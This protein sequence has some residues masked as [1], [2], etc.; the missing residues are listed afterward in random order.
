MSNIVLSQPGGV[1]TLTADGNIQVGTRCYLSGTGVVAVSWTLSSVPAGSTATAKLHQTLGW[2]FDPDVRSETAYVARMVDS[3]AGVHTNS[4]YASSAPTAP[5]V[6]Q[7]KATLYAEWFGVKADGRRITDGIVTAGSKILQSS[8]A[9]FTPFDV[10]RSALLRTAS[11]RAQ[12]TLTVV[13][14]NA[15]ATVNGA[16]QVADMP[17]IGGGGATGQPASGGAICVGGN[18]VVVTFSVP[19]TN[20]FVLATTPT[21]N[22]TGMPYY[23]ETQLATTIVRY[24]DATHVELAHA[25]TITE[26]SVLG[27]IATDDTTALDDC[28]RF[29]FSSGAVRVRLP[30]GLLGISTNLLYRGKSALTIAGPC[31][32]KD[33]RR[34]SL[35]YPFPNVDENLGAL[36]FVQCD[37]IILEDIS[38]DGSVSVL[39]T[40]HS[41][42]GVS[43]ASGSRIGLFMRTC[44]NSAYVRCGSESHGARDEHLYV[45]G[46]SANFTFDRCKVIQNN[47][48]SMNCNAGFDG[49]GVA[50]AKGLRFIGCRASGILVS[51]G[52]YVIE[53]CEITG[54]GLIGLGCGITVDCI[55]NGIIK[56]NTF[57]NITH[58]Q[59]VG[60]IDAFG[61]ADT[62]AVLVI[63][64]NTFRDTLHPAYT[65]G[66]AL[67]HLNNF[68]GTAFISG[69]VSEV[70]EST[71]PGG[72]YVYVE[73]AQTGTVYIGANVWHGSPGMTI[74]YA[75]HAA[76]PTASVVIAPGTCFDSNITTKWSLGA[77][78]DFPV[79]RGFL[80]EELTVDPP[81]PPANQAVF[82]LKDN[83]AGKTTAYIRFPTGAIQQVAIEP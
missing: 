72:R 67:V 19:S 69:N 39:Y 57:H 12:D 24:I 34:S 64:N 31:T 65:G 18:Y 47:S 83:G 40:V 78:C 66:G 32:L 68:R 28:L 58:F 44:T 50:A 36:S 33:L 37:G 14:G 81:A 29:A 62:G 30:G 21:F 15:V 23:T 75:V 51:S 73:G 9:A 80:M 3:V 26:S 70:C 46:D 79:D 11:G 43:N 49:L 74:G 77:V 52:S 22:A 82:Y 38:Y 4:F 25:A 41:A 61:N 5:T 6:T 56:G 8:T 42:G 2:Y 60:I 17:V 59:G 48:V 7:P 45:D 53:G 16:H 1:G 71:A 10:G 63:A 20:N 76:V 55:G 35:E 27:F 13:S 54:D